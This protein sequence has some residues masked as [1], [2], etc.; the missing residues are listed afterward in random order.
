MLLRHDAYRRL[1]VEAYFQYRGHPIY[2]SQL[3]MFKSFTGSSRQHHEVTPDKSRYGG[4]AD[5]R[6]R[7]TA[8]ICDHIVFFQLGTS[9][10]FGELGIAVVYSVYEPSRK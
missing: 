7:Y 8:R 1:D 4:T 9:R 2:G 5:I 10:T 6:S 3:H